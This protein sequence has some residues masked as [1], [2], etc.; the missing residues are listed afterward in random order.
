MPLAL[1]ALTGANCLQ[2]LVVEDDLLLRED[3]ATYLWDCGCA[4]YEADS[5]EQAVAMCRAGLHVDV[6]FT[7]INLKGM[8]AGWEVAKVFRAAHPAVG[9]VYASGNSVDSSWC[10]PG[11]LFFRKPYARFEI[12]AACRHL[13]R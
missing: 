9:I 10:V 13:G 12:L 3:V 6:L 8:A 4:V 11:S 7:D 1:P 2:V 5:A